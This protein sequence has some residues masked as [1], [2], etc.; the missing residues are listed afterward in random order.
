VIF[1][2][3][4]TPISGTLLFGGTDEP[5]GMV[6]HFGDFPLET[7]ADKPFKIGGTAAIDIDGY[8]T[9]FEE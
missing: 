5:R 6:H 7:V 4:T 9:Y 1:Y 2:S 8:I 3:D